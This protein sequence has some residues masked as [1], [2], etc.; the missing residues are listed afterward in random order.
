LNAVHPDWE[1][2]VS[3]WKKRDEKEQNERLLRA[4]FKPE[5]IER[6]R[7]EAERE[8]SLL[9]P[10]IGERLRRRDDERE[11]ALHAKFDAALEKY[12]AGNPHSE[13]FS[14]EEE[15]KFNEYL[16]QF[17]GPS[18]AEAV[19]VLAEAL[20]REEGHI[21]EARRDLE[22]Q[23]RAFESTKA[24]AAAASEKDLG[25][26]QLDFVRGKNG[27]ILSPVRITGSAGSYDMEIE[28]GAEGR[29]SRATL[30]PRNG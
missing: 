30:K 1:K 9:R 8:F 23:R 4:W 11:A 12:L 26:V 21:F 19:E 18:V 7:K 5:F 22:E 17:E 14:P 27:K 3:A 28:R 10:E 25:E 6:H 20:Q 16:A 2:R 24:A 15:A 13:G 29:I